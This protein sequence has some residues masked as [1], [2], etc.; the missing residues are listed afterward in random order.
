MH[1]EDNS[2]FRNLESGP[3][4]ASEANYTRSRVLVIYVSRETKH[5]KFFIGKLIFGKLITANP[6]FKLQPLDHM[7]VMDSET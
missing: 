1:T 2:N 7:E 3:S 5:C 4:T 6:S